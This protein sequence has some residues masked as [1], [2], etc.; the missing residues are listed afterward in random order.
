MA[1]SP[2]SSWVDCGH[3]KDWSLSVYYFPVSPSA[4][5]VR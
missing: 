3:K 2:H 5:P 4:V 1:E